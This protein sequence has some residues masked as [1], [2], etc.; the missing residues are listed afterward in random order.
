M[1]ATEDRRTAF[2]LQEPE[3]RAQ[4]TVMQVSRS[5]ENLSLGGVAALNPKTALPK[6]YRA[7]QPGEIS[8]FQGAGVI[9]VTRLA[10]GEVR[11]LL[12]QPHKGNKK[13]VRWFDFGGRKLSRAEFTSACACRKFAKQTYGVFGC[14]LD[15]DEHAV[16]HLNELYQGL[17]NLPLMLLASQEWAKLQMLDVEDTRIFYND[18]HEYHA[19][20]LCVP[21]VPEGLLTKIS[22]I[23]DGGKRRFKW[24]SLEELQEE[25]L[26]PRLH[27]ASLAKQL[28]HLDTDAWVRT[29]QA[30]GDGILGKATGCFSAKSARGR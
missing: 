27:T 25:V 4:E 17:A 15:L 5:L 7:A 10:S 18:I 8:T 12:W 23:V 19:Y 2:A 13:G 26:A 1:L 9:P 28:E 24:L 30:Y 21:F 16:E 3:N 22:E 6:K 20:M 11:I 14:Q 29:C